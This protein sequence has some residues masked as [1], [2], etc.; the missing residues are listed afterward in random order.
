M[1]LEIKDLVTIYNVSS[2][3]FVLLVILLL[4][5]LT[6]FY[7]IPRIKMGKYTV[8][9][10]FINRNFSDFIKTDCLAC[11]VSSGNH[12]LV[13]NNIKHRDDTLNCLDK[14]NCADKFLNEYSE[15]EKDGQIYI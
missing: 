7:I 14:I 5:W 4:G 8:E 12:A 9:K 15:A 3:I 6:L 11:D 13:F 1:K 2:R 10:F